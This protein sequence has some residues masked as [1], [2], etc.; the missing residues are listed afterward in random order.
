M[1]ALGLLV[2]CCCKDY[3]VSEL[4]ADYLQRCVGIES[5]EESLVAAAHFEASLDSTL[6]YSSSDLI[7]DVVWACY[8]G[9]LVFVD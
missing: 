6:S 4:S 2:T 7:V 8:S 9:T 1:P 3:V 5:F